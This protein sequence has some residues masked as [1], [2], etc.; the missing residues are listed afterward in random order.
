MIKKFESD[1]N[2]TKKM[3][4]KHFID[5][6]ELTPYLEKNIPDFEGPLIIE[7]FIGGQSNPTYFLKTN[8]NSYAL[9]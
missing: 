7:E 6:K 1:F 3:S 5:S 4:E 8:E 2:G 9:R